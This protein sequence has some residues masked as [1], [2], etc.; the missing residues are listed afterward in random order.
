MTRHAV[1]APF[2][3]FAAAALL[4]VAEGGWAGWDTLG[5]IAAMV[6]L[7]AVIYAMLAVAFERGVNMI[8]WA[9]EQKR[10]RAEEAEKRGLE[11]GMER[12]MEK[13]MERGMEK[14]MERG[15]DRGRADLIA[16]LLASGMPKTNQELEEWAKERGIPLDQAPRQ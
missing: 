7:A 12:G 13:G 15:M 6:D 11:K 4:A 5:P 14:G 1:A 9:L 2:G 3:I 16:E 10:K 8:W